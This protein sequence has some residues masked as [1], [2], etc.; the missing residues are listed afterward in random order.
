MNPMNYELNDS[1][2]D[3]IKKYYPEYK[4]APYQLME[5][6]YSKARESELI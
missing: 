4:P 6:L 3:F 1:Q 5:C 2:N